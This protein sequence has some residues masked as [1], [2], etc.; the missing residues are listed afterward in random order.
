[1][2]MD[3]V[4]VL[5]WPG[6]DRAYLCI[7][8]K[9]RPKKRVG[10]H[11]YVDGQHT[12]YREKY[13][14]D[15]LKTEPHITFLFDAGDVCAEWDGAYGPIQ[16]WFRCSADF[17]EGYDEAREHWFYDHAYGRGHWSQIAVSEA[18]LPEAF[19]RGDYDRIFAELRSWAQS[20]QQGD[21]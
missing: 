15:E 5:P 9:R 14:D 16:L 10:D 20:R 1:M 18:G 8:G 21:T 6:I 4:K 3:R 12:E 7:S 11:W 17:K 2:P 19:A 13:G